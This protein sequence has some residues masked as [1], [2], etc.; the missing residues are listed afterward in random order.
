MICATNQKTLRTI[1]EIKY[2]KEITIENKGYYESLT[3]HERTQRDE[4]E[5]FEKKQQTQK[6]IICTR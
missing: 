3:L 1:K 2:V 6:V 4:A 5:P